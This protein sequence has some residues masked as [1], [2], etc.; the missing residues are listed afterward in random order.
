MD[1]LHRKRKNS[2]VLPNARCWATSAS[3]VRLTT[4]LDRCKVDFIW[5]CTSSQADL[6]TMGL[7]HLYCGCIQNT[8]N[9]FSYYCG[10]IQNTLLEFQKFQPQYSYQVY[11]YKTNKIIKKRSVVMV[12]IMS[13]VRWTCQV[14]HVT[15]GNCAQV[16]QT[17]KFLY[18][19]KWKMVWTQELHILMKADWSGK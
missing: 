15:W 12:Y 8:L 7:V 19:W 5:I 1:H 9:T 16:H 4:S 13:C 6:L 11:S 18:E 2:G 14:W 10:S 3:L 17:G